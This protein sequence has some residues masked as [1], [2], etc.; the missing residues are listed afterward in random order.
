MRNHII[1]NIFRNMDNQIWTNIKD[2]KPDG[3]I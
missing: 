2:V 1:E 3:L